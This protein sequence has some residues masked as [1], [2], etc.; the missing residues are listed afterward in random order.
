MKLFF[1]P[2][3]Y[4]AIFC[5]LL[6]S[7]YASSS[8]SQ[9]E[10][11]GNNGEEEEEDKYNDYEVYEAIENMRKLTKHDNFYDLIGITSN[12]SEEEIGRAF[13]K[14]SVKYHPDKHG[15]DKEPMFKLVQYVGLLLRDPKRRAR[16]EWLLHDAPAWHRESVYAVRRVSKMAK[17]SMR[18]FWIVFF[19]FSIGGQILAQWLSYFVRLGRVKYARREV[20]AMGDKEVKKIRRKLESG[21]FSKLDRF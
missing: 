18:Q 3:I 6:S 15:K 5:L 11:K 1:V 14:M 21:I 2:L 13:R 4:L 10:K 9:N 20:N 17:L 16:Y 19:A 12:A 7:A 8:S